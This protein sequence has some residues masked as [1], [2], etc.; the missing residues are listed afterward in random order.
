MSCCQMHHV[1]LNAVA[2]CQCIMVVYMWWHA[3]R[4]YCIISAVDI[5]LVLAAL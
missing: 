4:L 5:A 1:I 3:V 2:C